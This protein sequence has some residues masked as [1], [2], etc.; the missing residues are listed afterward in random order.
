MVNTCTKDNE[1][2]NRFIWRRLESLIDSCG[3]K[4]LT[5][6]ITEKDNKEEGYITM[7]FRTF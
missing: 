2:K 3:S 6:N 5:Y 1:E 7:F 4:Q